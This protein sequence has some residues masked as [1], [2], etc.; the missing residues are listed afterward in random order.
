MPPP[1]LTVKVDLN[2]STMCGSYMLVSAT[3][4]DGT[5]ITFTADEI[6]W[7]EIQADLAYQ[8]DSVIPIALVQGAV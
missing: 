1:N 5:E 3:T 6:L 7:R 2:S 4:E 8:R